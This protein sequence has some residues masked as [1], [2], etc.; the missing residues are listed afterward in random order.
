MCLLSCHAFSSTPVNYYWTK[1]DQVALSSN[2]KVMKNSIAVTPRD[3]QDY[4]VY[5]CNASNSF[6][7]TAYNITLSESHEPPIDLNMSKG[8][9]EVDESLSKC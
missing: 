8:D 2:I 3:A 1:D 5:V 9:D 4:G 6:G 7:S